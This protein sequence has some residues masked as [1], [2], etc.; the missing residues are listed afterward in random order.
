M[1]CW[2]TRE[3]RFEFVSLLLERY[4]LIRTATEEAAHIEL[5]ESWQAEM[6]VLHGV[7]QFVEE[8]G[9]SERLD[10]DH[11]IL[12]RNTR[13]IRERRRIRDSYFA[14]LPVERGLASASSHNSYILKQVC[15]E[16]RL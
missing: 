9:S 6:D 3:S 10:V 1:F 7:N 11:D 13:H 8:K 15:G 5:G 14:K 2:V 12:E 16:E 4:L